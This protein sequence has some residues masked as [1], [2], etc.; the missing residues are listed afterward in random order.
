MLDVP[1]ANGRIYEFA[2]HNDSREG[3]NRENIFMIVESI[4]EEGKTTF[5]PRGIGLTN[6]FREYSIRHDLLNPL[7][8]ATHQKLFF[9]TLFHIL[10]EDETLQSIKDTILNNKKLYPKIQEVTGE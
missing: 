3:D 8:I 9:Y 6:N 10:R 4:I 1:G 5:V 2:I 7:S